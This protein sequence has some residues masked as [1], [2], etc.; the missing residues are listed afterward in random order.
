MSPRVFISYSH[1]SSDH[2]DRV[3]SLAE[4]LRKDGIHSCIDQALDRPPPEGWPAWMNHQLKE[5][6]FVLVVCTQTYF[7]RAASVEKPGTGKGVKWE[8]RLIQQMIYDGNSLNPKIIPVLLGNTPYAAIPEWLRPDS[9]YQ[10]DQR[11]DYEQLFGHITG[12]ALVK[13]SEPG[14]VRKILPQKPGPLFQEPHNPPMPRHNL[15]LTTLGELFMGRDRALKQLRARFQRKGTLAVTQPQVLHGLGG[16]GKSRL[17]I[18]Y[19][20]RY[21]PNYRLVAF[22]VADSPETLRANLA[23]LDDLMDLPGE[24]RPEE[25]RLKGVLRW[26]Q[27]HRDWL[28][29]LDNIDDGESAKQAHALL[30]QL[31]GGHVL[32]TSRLTAWPQDID[33]RDLPFLHKKVAVDLLV[34]ST[35][36]R[37]IRRRGDR[38]LAGKLAEML[39]YLPLAL[40]QAAAYINHLGL[41]FEAYLEDWELQRSRVLDW[42]DEATMNYPKA[43]AVTWQKSFDRLSSLAQVLLRIAAHLSPEPI[44][45]ELFQDGDADLEAAT[46]AL[47]EERGKAGPETSQVAQALAECAGFSLI[48]RGDGYFS[49]HRMLGEVLRTRVPKEKR[50]SWIIRALQLVEKVTPAD[51]H[52]NPEAWPIWQIWRSH[53]AHLLQKA[54]RNHVKYP[55]TNLVRGLGAYLIDQ[56]VYREAESLCRTYLALKGSLEKSTQNESWIQSLLGQVLR[57]LGELEEARDLM[58]TSLDSAKESYKEGHPEITKRQSNLAGLLK[59]L[60]AFK[61]ARDLMRTALDSAEKSYEAGHPAIAACQSNLALVLRDLGELEEARDLMRTALDSAEKSY[62]EGHP[63]IAIRQSNLAL[64]LRDLGELEE[65][66]ILLRAALDSDQKGYEAGHPEIAIRQSN[67]ALVLKEMGELE[68]ARDLLQSALA[69]DEKSYE[70][71]HPAIARSQSNLAIVLKDLGELGE[72]ETLLREALASNEKS[73]AAGHPAIAIRQSSLALVL[74]DFGELEEARKL[75]RSAL[76]SAGKNYEAGHPA[77]AI[78]QS[79]LA[80]V[81]KDLGELEKARDLLQKAHGAFLQKL[82]P[83]HR[84]T[85]GTLAHLKLLDD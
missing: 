71:G 63:A 29:I 26:F 82:G 21:G 20:W 64:V 47:L 75:L 44:P 38:G 27:E 1:D 41:S 4:Q 52:G 37:R 36:G 61:E 66:R 6:D 79:N 2:K 24:G 74:Q 34:K 51:T 46:N 78:N 84:Y 35:A 60:G 53:A 8:S 19:A 69:S 10:A 13:M 67:L 32:I 3:L 49:L 70:E 62:E 17:A 59:D 40:E 48:Q 65:A 9:H 80:L 42:Y 12:Q 15:P 39:G 54:F 18:E 5:A 83:N 81:L 22:A 28:L 72:A 68:E 25:E 33:T 7:E 77:I 73:Y 58:R 85:Q 45:T 14:P 55:S 31:S 76:V 23:N 11:A 16:I 56:A 43:V 57:G 50:P 30:P